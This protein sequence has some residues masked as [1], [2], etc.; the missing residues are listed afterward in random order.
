M[1]KNT[2]GGKGSK[3]L[4]RKLVNSDNNTSNNNVR[5]PDNELEVFAIVTKMFGTMCEVVTSDNKTYKCHIRG[6]FRGRSKR[7][8]I[9]SIG[10]IVLVGF[11][12]FEAPLFKN[13]DLLEIYEPH[14]ITTLNTFYSPFSLIHT[15]LLFHFNIFNHIL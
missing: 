10:K 3:S 5:I 7:F 9:V 2:K 15:Q 13:T 6:K 11:R 14:D 8:S 1:V 12:D 4:S